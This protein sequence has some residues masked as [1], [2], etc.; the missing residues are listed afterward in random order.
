M[1]IE[2]VGRRCCSCKNC[3]MICPVNAIRFR[4]DKYGFEYPEINYEKCI[5]CGRCYSICPVVNP[6]NI[7][8]EVYE[9]GVAYS[10]DNEVKYN[11]SSGGLFGTFA[12]AIINQEGIVFGAAFDS[13]LQL[14][15]T[16]AENDEELM[17]LY[18]SKYLLCDTYNEFNHIKEELDN[19]RKVLYCATPCQIH[20]LK[21][22]LKKEY[23]NLFLIDFVCHGVGSQDALNRSVSYSEKKLKAKIKKI[24]FRYKEKDASSHYYC[25][26]C[27]KEKNIFTKKDLYLTFPYYNA[28]CKQLVCRDNCYDC[29][30]ASKERVSDITIGDFHE[31]AKYDSSIDRFAGVSMF[32]CNTEKGYSL[33]NR[34]RNQL[35]I[36]NMDVNILYENNRFDNHVY[37]PEEREAFLE[38]LSSDSFDITVKKFLNPSKDWKR[39]IYYNS[40]SIIRKIARK[41]VGE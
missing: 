17:P 27:E 13:D 3:E 12:K 31:I 37:I 21:L 36:K 1:N 38:S 25:F 28:Y 41:M 35:F 22:Y 32:L 26:H 29:P 5:D 39:I 10:L 7:K 15:T 4:K 23:S 34:V 19:E 30:F 18:K 20:A 14:K 24:V 2:H 9:S 40:P 8:K 16:S 33:L 6:A 11:G